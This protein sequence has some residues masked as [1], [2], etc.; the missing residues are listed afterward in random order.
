MF[1]Y[2]AYGGEWS[3]WHS[4]FPILFMVVMAIF[5]MTMMGRGIMKGGCMPMMHG[6]GKDENSDTPHDIAKRRYAAG[7]IGRDE[8]LLLIKEIGESEKRLKS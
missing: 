8:Y 4:L 1:E 5:C 7:E 3:G 6:G 2:M